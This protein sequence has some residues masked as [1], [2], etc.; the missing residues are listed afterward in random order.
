MV[1]LLLKLAFAGAFLFVVWSY[2]PVAGRTLSARWRTADSPVAFVRDGLAEA[3]LAETPR[4]EPRARNTPRA[5]PERVTEAERQALD[6][7]LAEELAREG[8]N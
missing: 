3:G 8:R 5:R 7:R 4:P 6:R 1:R 2:V